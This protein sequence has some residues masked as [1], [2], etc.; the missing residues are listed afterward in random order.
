MNTVFLR[1]YIWFQDLASREEGQDLVEYALVVALIAFGATAG[2][3]SLAT[4]LTTA[5]HGISTTL[6]SYVS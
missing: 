1:A 6:G 4:G 5:F 3:K 2:M